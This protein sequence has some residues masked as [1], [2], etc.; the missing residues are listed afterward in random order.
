MKED[1]LE[2][3]VDEYLQLK[4]FFT[5][6]NVKFYPSKKH[7]EYDSGQDRV[8]SD[9]DIIGFNPRRKGHDRTWVVSCKSWQGGFS[10]AEWVT[11]IDKNKHVFGRDA[12]RGFRELV[13]KKWA[14]GLL[15]EVKKRT[16]STK[17]T[18]ITAVTRLKGKAAHRALWQEHP[19]FRKNLRGNP[20]RFI[21][22]DEILKE[23]FK[24]TKKTVA[25][26]Q[27]GRFVQVMKASGWKP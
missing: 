22:L 2:Q 24:E 25:C 3:L 14:D 21:T 16:G 19:L 4:N 7:P 1:I 12:W 27:I 8:A 9:V 10:P 13:K 15:A 23:V 5:V 18:Y 26:S 6:H 17:F 11:R 20:I